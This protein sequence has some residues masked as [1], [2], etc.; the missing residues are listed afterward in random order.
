MV[1]SHSS[2]FYFFSR[3]VLI[4]YFKKYR[5]GQ[6]LKLALYLLSRTL[7]GHSRAT[8][9]CILPVVFYLIFFMYMYMV[10]TCL[11][12][13]PYMYTVGIAAYHL[14][15]ARRSWTGYFNPSTSKFSHS[16]GLLYSSQPVPV[17]NELKHS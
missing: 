4:S 15:R 13:L 16:H 9:T 11:F 7:T 17:D 10:C 6:L 1:C 2:D 3:G 5:K 14:L 8:C 12:S